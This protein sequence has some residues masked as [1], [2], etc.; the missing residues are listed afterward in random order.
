MSTQT[1]KLNKSETDKLGKMTTTSSRIRFL[2]S[3]GWSR[4]EVARKLGIIYQ[5]VYNV[6]H[7]V[8]KNPKV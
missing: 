4:G 8:V 1:N 5:W 6:E 2:L 3:K 7:Q